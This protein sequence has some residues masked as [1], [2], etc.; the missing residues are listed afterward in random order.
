VVTGAS[1]FIGPELVKL[2]LSLNYRVRCLVRSRRKLIAQLGKQHKA[3]EIYDYSLLNPNPDLFRDCDIV[4]H[5]AG[6]TKALSLADFERV[7]VQGTIVVAQAALAAGVKRFV[8]ISTLA[9]TRPTL[10]PLIED[11]LPPAPVSDYGK[12]KAKAEQALIATLS[13]KMEFTIIRPAAVY[14]EKDTEFAP[15]YQ[16]IKVGIRP[17]VSWDQNPISLVHVSDLV[18]AIAYLMVLPQ[19]ADR[20]FTVASQ[21]VS[22]ARFIDAIVEVLGVTPRTVHISNSVLEGYAEFTANFAKLIRIPQMFTPSKFLELSSPWNCDTENLE[23]TGF[24]FEVG[25]VHGLSFLSK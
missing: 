11:E 3:V 14:G 19:A 7:N 9:A 17:Q 13:R 22:V 25:L 2:L 20:T 24:E 16:L 1:G 12:S 18:R 21:I 6:A 4:I 23:Q 8:L 15:L 5:N 10:L